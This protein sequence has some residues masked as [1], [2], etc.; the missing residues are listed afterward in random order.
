MID[1]GCE[2][3]DPKVVGGSATAD[4]GKNELQA[5]ETSGF[6]FAGTADFGRNELQ[7]SEV[8]GLGGA[9]CIW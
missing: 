4:L 9:A 7:A 6:G 2:G 1:P 3:N 5:S 8:G